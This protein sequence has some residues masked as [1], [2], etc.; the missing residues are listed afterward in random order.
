[1]K[2]SAWVATIGVAWAGLAAAQIQFECPNTLQ[3]EQ[4]AAAPTALWESVDLDEDGRHRLVAAGLFDGP[5]LQRLGAMKPQGSEGQPRQGR[6]VQHFR[7]TEPPT[8]GVFLVCYYDRTSVV[9]HRRIEPGPRQCSLETVRGP[10]G[11]G[12]AVVRCQ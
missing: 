11:L 6:F 3:V 8:A 9:A 5:P 2:R 7:W 10:H 1:M 12:P 4:K